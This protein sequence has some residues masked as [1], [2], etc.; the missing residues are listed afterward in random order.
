MEIQTES[1]FI[2]VKS[3]IDRFKEEW[4]KLSATTVFSRQRKFFIQNPDLVQYGELARVNGWKQPLMFALRGLLVYAF[5][6]SA[7]SWLITRDEG[8]SADDIAKV[9][10]ELESQLRTEQGVM[11]SAQF[12]ID[13]IE[14]SRKTSGFNVATSTNLT[15]EEAI[16]QL[17][18]QI[19]EARKGQ[20]EDKLKAELRI[21]KLRAA[22]DRFA[23]LASGTAVVFSL[24]LIFAAPLFRMVMQRQ[25]GRYKLT[26]QSDTYYLY[27]VVSRG[28]WL[29]L[30]VVIVLNL[31]LSGSAYGLGGLT[32]TVGPIGKAIFW[33]A[34]YT[35]VLYWFFI[36][37]KDLHKAMQLPRLKDYTGMENKVLLH[38]HNTFWVTFVAFEALLALL[39]YGVYLMEK[40]A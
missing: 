26:A 7:F 32:E 14:K 18:A 2:E 12:E 16:R 1:E 9:R 23:L 19:D 29:N 38:M 37:S 20:E 11:D 10:T 36:V 35:L 25:Y 17:N 40:P 33:L 22:G 21:Q 28:V 39:A 24:A 27:Y 8:K 6:L 15:K 4:T 34:L 5:L 13:R 30:A 31:G 3:P